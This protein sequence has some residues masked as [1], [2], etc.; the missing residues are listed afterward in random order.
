MSARSIVLNESSVIAARR[1][2]LRQAH[3]APLVR[4]RRTLVAALPNGT[5]VPQ[6]D[7]LDAGVNAQIL[8]LLDTPGSAAYCSSFTS[9]DNPS[10]TSA[11]LSELLTEAGI[12]RSRVLMWN[13]VP[14][15]IS[16]TQTAGQPTRAQHRWQ[17]LPHLVRLLSRLPKLRVVVL[18]GKA[19]WAAK[20]IRTARPDLEPV[21][22]CHPSG[23][24]LNG[25]PQRR[26][27]ILAALAAANSNR[28]AR[29]TH[30]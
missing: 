16:G 10:G 25:R 4:F 15:D 8:L 27:G 9:L 6:F 1:R 19:K 13:L 12:N 24:A 17:G 29:G 11:S 7:P 2:A 3:V 22:C 20:H 23:R 26:A 14:W 30:G 21:I 18:F 5:F 28:G